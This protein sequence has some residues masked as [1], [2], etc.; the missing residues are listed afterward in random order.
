MTRGALPGWHTSRVDPIE[1]GPGSAARSPL[2]LARWLL[3]GAIIA[4]VFTLHVLTA[5]SALTG[6]AHYP[7]DGLTL[8]VTAPESDRATDSGGAP[9]SLAVPSVG[10]P[11]DTSG[12]EGLLI[13]CIMFLVVAGPAALLA[14]LV[15]RPGTEAAHSGRGRWA[16]L[17]RRGPPGPGVPRLALCVIRI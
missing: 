17:S 8:P 11:G 1:H 6:S 7:G 3:L 9:F 16:G 5:E 15:R 4:G 14:L 13:G 2:S 10:Q 12:G